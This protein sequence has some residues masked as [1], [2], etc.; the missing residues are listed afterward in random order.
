VAQKAVA[1]TSEQTADVQ[2]EDA[3][4]QKRIVRW[5]VRRESSD[6]K[7]GGDLEQEPPVVE[8]CIVEAAGTHLRFRTPSSPGAYRLFVFVYDNQGNAATANVPFQVQ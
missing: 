2:V 6:R 7:T 5:E 4:P 3:T 8:N 1:S